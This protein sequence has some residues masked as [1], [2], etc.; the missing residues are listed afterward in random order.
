MIVIPPPMYIPIAE[1][2]AMPQVFL[3]VLILTISSFV[4]AIMLTLLKMFGG[5]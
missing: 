5:K 4:L 1:I 2:I 3:S